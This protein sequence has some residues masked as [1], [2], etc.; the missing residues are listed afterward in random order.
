MKKILFLVFLIMCIF[1]TGC[2]QTTSQ[3]IY[4]IGREDEIGSSTVKIDWNKEEEYFKVQY[5]MKK[6][7]SLFEF[8]VIVDHNPI[9]DLT[10]YNET[11][12]KYFEYDDNNAPYFSGNTLFIISYKNCKDEFKNM[13]N[14]EEFSIEAFGETFVLDKDG[15]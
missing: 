8:L 12:D 11:Q 4:V 2:N 9:S 13:I 14:D 15:R 6:E 7:K 10:Y 3:R 1:L 5:K